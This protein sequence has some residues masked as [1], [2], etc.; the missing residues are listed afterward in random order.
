M[1]SVNL[2][3]LINWPDFRI[4][5]FI[6]GMQLANLSFCVSKSAAL[7]ICLFPLKTKQIKIGIVLIT[8]V[9]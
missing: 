3:F 2:F 8:T 6:Q 9:I 7:S 4:L 1:R 5:I